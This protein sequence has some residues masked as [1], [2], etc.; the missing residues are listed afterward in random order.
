MSVTPDKDECTSLQDEFKHLQ[1]KN[2]TD[3][4]WKTK[5]CTKTASRL[6][7]CS[8]YKENCGTEGDE[9]AEAE[10][11]FSMMNDNKSM[12]SILVFGLFV[13]L[14][15][16]VY[17]YGF[18]G[19]L[20]FE[21]NLNYLI[22]ILFSGLG[23]ILSIMLIIGTIRHVSSSTMS[24]E[25]KSTSRSGLLVI[26]V[27]IIF[28]SMMGIIRYNYGKLFNALNKSLPAN[29]SSIWGSKGQKRGPKKGR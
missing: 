23:I 25:E 12:N 27:L 18:H 9:S 11:H 21:K 26:V 1:E 17:M 24:D 29:K 8:A 13:I 20:K 19:I 6:P 4:T 7:D 10:E 28:F 3:T 5:W 22:A 2:S 15:S 16:F 14:F